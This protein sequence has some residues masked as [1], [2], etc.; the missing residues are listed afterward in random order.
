VSKLTATFQEREQASAP[1]AA[2]ALEERYKR[3]DVG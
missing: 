1:I 3:I 2:G